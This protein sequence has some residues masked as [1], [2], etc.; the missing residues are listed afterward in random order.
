VSKNLGGLG[1]IWGACAPWPQRR[2]A[3]AH[4]HHFF[5]FLKTFFG[6]LVYTRHQGYSAMMSCIYLVLT[7]WT[8]QRNITDWS[9]RQRWYEHV[10]EPSDDR[11][12]KQS[13][14]GTIPRRPPVAFSRS[15]STRH[16]PS[17]TANP[18]SERPEN[19]RKMHKTRISKVDF[20]HFLYSECSA[21]Q[22]VELLNFISFNSEMTVR[23]WF[24]K[25]V[26]VLNPNPVNKV[27]FTASNTNKLFTYAR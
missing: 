7:Y 20:A 2:T 12:G 24:I 6:I 27:F 11:W 3:T 15:P 5:C 21:A 14:S 13:R 4:H 19:A 1:K 16:R 26:A 22:Y 23:L 9:F 25:K 10:W 18:S 8:D 17:S